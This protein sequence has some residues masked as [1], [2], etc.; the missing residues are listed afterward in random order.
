MEGNQV[1]FSTESRFNFSSDDNRVRVW[2]PRGEHLNP[3]CSLQRH[4]APT[5]GVMVW[6][7]IAYSTRLPLLFTRDTMTGQR[8]VHEILQPHVL[9]LM[10]R[11]PGAIFQKRQDSA[12]HGKGIKRLSLHC[13]YSS[14][15]CQIPSLSP[16]EHI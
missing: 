13:Y 9:P 11:L 5:T 1:V 16:I 10:Q 4:T 14:L 3:A 12:S 8:Y 7:V 2:R 6:G 15:A